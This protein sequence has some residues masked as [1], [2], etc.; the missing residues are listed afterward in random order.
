[1]PKVVDHEERRAAV[2]LATRSVVAAEGIDAA[3]M[4]RIAEAAQCTTGRITHYFADKRE[5]LVAVLREV[6]A[7][8]GRRM[9]AQMRSAAPADRLQ[10]VLEESLPLDE[11]RLDEWRVWLAFWGRAVGDPQLRDE[12]RTRYREW[13]ELVAELLDR[14][15]AD[16]EVEALLAVIDGIGL[17]ATLDADA[18]PADRQ[19]AAL[20][21]HLEHRS[22]PARARNGRGVN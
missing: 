5:V 8:A 4:R 22:P 11:V 17:R 20:S 21:A 13:T 2:I 14:S 15:P 10:R 18:F 16:P 9:A 19:L 3:T 1:M 12:Q 7:A 6:H